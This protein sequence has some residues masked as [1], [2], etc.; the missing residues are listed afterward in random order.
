MHYSLFIN[1][2]RLQVIFLLL[3]N[4]YIGELSFAYGTGLV[5]KKYKINR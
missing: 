2:P 1:K 5:T 4:Y 3:I